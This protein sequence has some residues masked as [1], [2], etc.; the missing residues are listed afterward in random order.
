[1]RGEVLGRVERRR[2]WSAGEKLAVV[3]ASL[4]PGAVVATVA[5][6]FDVTRQQVYDWR[7]AAR[8]G[9]LGMPGGVVG[10]VE[11]VAETP[12][13]GAA[14]EA[15]AAPIAR[16][17]ESATA[18]IVTAPV[19]TVEIVLVGGRVLRAPAGL[20]TAELRRLIGAVEDA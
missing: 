5:R 6:R 2:R 9:D 18:P 16:P 14:I 8:R 11:V 10:F 15:E 19:V 4:E 1:M 12:A 20:P 17:P 3:M 13:H 7:R